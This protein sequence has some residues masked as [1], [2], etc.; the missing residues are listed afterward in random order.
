MIA[1][2]YPPQ[3]YYPNG[4]VA[5][6]AAAVYGVPCSTS[7]LFNVHAPVFIPQQ[8]SSIRTPIYQER[9]HANVK[10]ASRPPSK[11]KQPKYAPRP[12]GEFLD[13]D[14]QTRRNGGTM[15]KD[16]YNE[17]TEYVHDHKWKMAPED[18]EEMLMGYF[19]TRNK[20]LDADSM[21][22]HGLVPFLARNVLEQRKKEVKKGL[23]PQYLYACTGR[24]NR[25]K[26]GKSVIRE[27]VIDFAEENGYK[28][29]YMPENEGVV[30]IKFSSGRQ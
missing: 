10:V 23:R 5:H 6:Q 24:G 8:A 2:A 26:T 11:P 17:L 12:A 14:A 21:D 3:Y 30:V 4:F 20:H 18:F 7:T 9:L 28:W 22:L 29:C 13:L 19:N 1:T 15:T 25:S 27:T 16:F